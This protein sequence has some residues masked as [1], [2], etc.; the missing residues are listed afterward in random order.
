MALLFVL[1]GVVFK[2]KQTNRLSLSE[3]TLQEIHSLFHTDYCVQKSYYGMF[4]SFFFFWTGSQIAGGVGED[5]CKINFV[6]FQFYSGSALTQ[7][8]E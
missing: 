1:E 6:Y 3:L 5:T 7:D 8:L 4:L 2:N